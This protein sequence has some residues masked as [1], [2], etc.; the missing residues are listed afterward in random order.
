MSIL[1]VAEERVFY[2]S[3]GSERITPDSGADLRRE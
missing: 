2:A 3:T 1:F